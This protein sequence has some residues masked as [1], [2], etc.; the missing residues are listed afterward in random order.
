MPSAIT[1]ASSLAA[2]AIGECGASQTLLGKKNCY[3]ALWLSREAAYSFSRE[4]GLNKIASREPIPSPAIRKVIAV[5]M[6]YSVR[7]FISRTVQ[8]LS[9]AGFRTSRCDQPQSQ[10]RPASHHYEIISM[11]STRMVLLFISSFPVT[12][13]CCPIYFFAFAGSSNL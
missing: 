8:L 6:S 13:T 10:F 3:T 2:L 7:F 1:G 9:D 4:C 12:F 11:L 5:G